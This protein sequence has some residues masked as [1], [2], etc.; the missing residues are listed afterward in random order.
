MWACDEYDEH[1]TSREFAL[2]PQ[3]SKKATKKQNNPVK[4][5]SD[6]C[7][8]RKPGALDRRIEGAIVSLLQGE[9]GS[10]IEKTAA[11]SKIVKGDPRLVVTCDEIEEI[12]FGS[13]FDPEKVHGRR[14]NRKSRAIGDPN[15]EWKSVDMEDSSGGD[16]SGE[17]DGGSVPSEDGGVR[18]RPPQDQSDVN[19][20][21]GGERSRAEKIEASVEDLEKRRQGAKRAEEREMV[22]R[23]A[24]RGIVFG[25]EVSK[26]ETSGPKQKTKAKAKGSAEGETSMPQTEIRKAE[27][28]MNGM[29]VEPSYAKGNWTIRW[30]E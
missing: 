14:K 4:Y 29:V 25:F 10:G 21:V 20:S 27:A 12:V 2:T 11:R 23:A 30:R 5:C 18:I 15:A 28:L 17:D 6:R 1:A 19:F 9:E 26:R 7:R 3:D 13:R 16:D 24:R 22:R 8:S